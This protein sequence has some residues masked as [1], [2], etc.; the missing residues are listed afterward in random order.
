M[1]NVNV[2]K[3]TMECQYRS[4]NIFRK[5]KWNENGDTKKKKEQDEERRK[6]QEIL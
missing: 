4:R 2:A 1:N 5:K 3:V 6:T